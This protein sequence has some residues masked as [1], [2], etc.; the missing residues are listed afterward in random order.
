M[1]DGFVRP[2]LTGEAL[3]CT[4][5]LPQGTTDLSGDVGWT[6]KSIG[7][8][9][10][11]AANQVKPETTCKLAG[12]ALA[13]TLFYENKRSEGMAKALKKIGMEVAP[14][15]VQVTFT[16]LRSGATPPALCTP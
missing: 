16:R 4:P 1:T 7:L 8:N 15:T 3:A 9:T 5:G 14:K 12:D 13:C 10:A 11:F 6:G 2:D